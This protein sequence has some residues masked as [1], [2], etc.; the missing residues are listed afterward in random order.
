MRYVAF[1]L[2]ASLVSCSTSTLDVEKRFAELGITRPESKNFIRG[3]A[4]LEASCKV[5][6]STSIQACQ[7]YAN[8]KRPIGDMEQFLK[9]SLF[10]PDSLVGTD[11][12]AFDNITLI[13][14]AYREY[15]EANQSS[16][17]RERLW[18]SFIAGAA[19]GTLFS[20]PTPP[21]QVN[22]QMYGS[23]NYHWGQCQ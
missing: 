5:S 19:F 18:N 7:F 17:D 11:R 6:D 3:M 23:G 4:A 21:P 10:N 12:S 2:F 1:L 14:A 8:Q 13:G 22:C 15:I 20:R 16:A 9:A